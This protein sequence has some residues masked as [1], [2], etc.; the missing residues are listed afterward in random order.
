MAHVAPPQPALQGSEV[1]GD[2]LCEPLQ[3]IAAV[4]GQRWCMSD[5]CNMPR[6][7][8][9]QEFPPVGPP[10]GPPV[11]DCT[12]SAALRAHATPAS[13]HATPRVALPRA[14]ASVLQ[15]QPGNPPASPPACT[16]PTPPT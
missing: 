3:R 6:T 7:R 4:W 1:R 8:I 11:P 12:V 16:P 15:P 14:A 9:E 5:Y 10:L 13:C 2:K